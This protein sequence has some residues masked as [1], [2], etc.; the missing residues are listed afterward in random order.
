MWLFI[1]SLTCTKK[2]PA[3]SHCLTWILGSQGPV[4]A[5]PAT[6]LSS[7]PTWHWNRYNLDGRNLV[8]IVILPPSHGKECVE[9]LEKYCSS[10][11]LPEEFSWVTFCS[12]SEQSDQRARWKKL[13]TIFHP[14]FFARSFRTTNVHKKFLRNNQRTSVKSSSRTFS[15]CLRTSCTFFQKDILPSLRKASFKHKD[16]VL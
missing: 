12:G 1:F 2:G 16:N 3:M 15:A 11:A 6:T 7:I 8:C 10:L 5:R 9:D 13:C 14:D 4:P